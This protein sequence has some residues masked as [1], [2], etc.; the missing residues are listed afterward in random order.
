MRFHKVGRD[1][2][3]FRIVG[4]DDDVTVNYRKDSV[5]GFTEAFGLGAGYLKLKNTETASLPASP[6]E[7]AIVYDSD[8][9]EPKYHNGTDWQT[10]GGTSITYATGTWAPNIQDSSAS[11]G[12]GQVVTANG[13]EYTRIGNM[14]YFSGGI[15]ISNLG[16]LGG[17]I[18]R[19]S[20]LP[21]TADTDAGGVTFTHMA[22][23]TISSMPLGVIDGGTSAILYYAGGFG[24]VANLAISD[25]SASTTFKFFGQYRIAT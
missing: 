19:L 10:M 22:N 6:S 14:C 4:D 8:D 7:G 24:G 5:S 12:E 16:T 11:D 13:A 25:L 17:S 9:Q 20:G 2:H 21:F 23:A 3:L 15:S 18:V 1:G